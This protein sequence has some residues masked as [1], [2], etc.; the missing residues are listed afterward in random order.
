MLAASYWSLLSPALEKAEASVAEG[1]AEDEELAFGQKLMVVLPV[2][3]GF[4]LGAA[5]VWIAGKYTSQFSLVDS[6]LETNGPGGA[7][8]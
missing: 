2:A 8:V 4:L 7:L 1:L 6:I 3:I 5:F